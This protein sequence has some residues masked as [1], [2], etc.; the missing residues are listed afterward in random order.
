MLES[1]HISNYA[2]IESVDVTFHHGLN[3]ITGE[4]GAGK[5]ILLGALS[6][7]LGG[8]LDSKTV[9]KP[10]A[11]T[12]VEAS[13]LLDRHKSLEEYCRVND[14]EWDPARCI[15]RR[16]INPNGRARAFVNDSPVPLTKLAGVAA[17][18]VDLHSQNRNQLLATPAFQLNVIDTL[19][20]NGDKLAEYA[21]RYEALRKA[22]RALK[23]AKV[24]VEQTRADE[25]FLRYQLEQLDTADIQP[26]ELDE[27]ERQRDIVANAADVKMRVLQALDA[28]T[29]AQQNAADLVTEAASA[30]RSLDNV[31][32]SRL[33]LPQRLDNI[34]IELRDIA[35]ELQ[36][37]DSTL[38]GDPE[39][40]TAI[41]ERISLIQNMMRR[42]HVANQNE[43]IGIRKSIA[44]RL[45]N[46]DNAEQLI[47]DLRK[48][49]RRAMALARETAEQLGESRKRAAESLAVRWADTAVPLGMKNLRAQIDVKP[50]DLG[51]TGSDDV[52]F[53][54]AFNKNQPL[55][56]LGGAASG[57]EISRLMLS[58]KSI[59]A[60]RIELPSIIFDEV[61]T[62]VSGDVAMRMGHLMRTIGRDIQVIAITHL[63]QVAAQGEHHYRV[64]KYDDDAGTHTGI[65]QLDRDQ[66][67][68]ELAVMLSGATDDP[69]GIAA[70]RALLDK[71]TNTDF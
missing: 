45:D 24:A 69:T 37:L 9:R 59:I 11:K 35:D 21:L 19:A 12:V 22:T 41:D 16:E 54:F 17:L 51:P 18:L 13:F 65:T 5:S 40:L 70:A 58:L 27:L 61:D 29:S 44:D 33:E 20:A 68:A 32:D 14:I 50:A 42:H 48:D 1:L 7:I 49:A 46:L 30:C 47:A 36:H 60:S 10:D 38:N 39:E 2:L 4:T 64:A 43:L 3:I 57:G 31:I 52:A 56:P 34:E 26:D 66:R 67:I 28:L 23:T 6:L 55:T 8:R 15:L 71:S 53:L 25:E 62:G 63:P